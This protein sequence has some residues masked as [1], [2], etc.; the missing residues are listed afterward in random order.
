MTTE[1]IKENFYE[2]INMEWLKNTVIPSDESR[3]S[4]FNIL[5]DQN[6]DKL[7][8]ILESPNSHPEAPKAKILYQQYINNNN[9]IQDLQ[10]F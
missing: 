10:K 3:W 9:S 2:F 6:Y 7:K 5:S 1:L 4:T 8:D